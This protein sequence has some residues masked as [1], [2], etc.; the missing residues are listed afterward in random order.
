MYIVLLCG[1]PRL[2]ARMNPMDPR[3]RLRFDG[4]LW[5]F[6]G[7]EGVEAARSHIPDNEPY[8]VAFAVALDTEIDTAALLRDDSATIYIDN[9]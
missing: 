1:C 2:R 7:D 3:R 8:V 5:T 9:D 6:E 4:R